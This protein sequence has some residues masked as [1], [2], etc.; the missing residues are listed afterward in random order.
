MHINN[1][2]NT[3]DYKIRISP[4]FK[5]NKIKPVKKITRDNKNYYYIHL[6]S[7]NIKIIEK[8]QLKETH[9]SIYEE[10]DERNPTLGPSHFTTIWA[11]AAGKSFRLHLFLNAKDRLACQPSWNEV[12]G[13][14][15]FS[16]AKLPTELES[17]IQ[18]VLQIGRPYLQ[19]LRQRQVLT[20]KS[21]ELKYQK[22]AK[23]LDQ[24]KN[25]S[26]KASY[27]NKL[28]EINS[29]LSNLK[30]VS[31]RVKWSKLTN[32]YT[33]LLQTFNQL[34]IDSSKDLTNISSSI[35]E[36]QPNRSALTQFSL[37]PALTKTKKRLDLTSHR[38]YS[39][40]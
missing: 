23:E 14:G 10:I 27:L 37:F 24:L 2:Y 17:L 4:H 1:L 5:L 12:K 21:L 38:N 20:E 39:P 8:W 6:P 33:H 13:P 15:Q 16:K 30:Q 28:Q 32:Y 19:Q 22:L 40:K 3:L 11:N 34:T 29:V 18:V 26:N 35:Q 7:Q 36:K 31:G 25:F 9:L